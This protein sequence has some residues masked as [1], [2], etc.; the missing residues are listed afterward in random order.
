MPAG[1]Q[2][3]NAAGQLIFD[4]STRASRVLG[5]VNITG[6]VDGSVAN[7][8]FAQGDPYW[9]CVQTVGL[10]TLYFGVTPAFSF[11]GTTLSWSFDGL[12]DNDCLLIYGVY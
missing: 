3:W 8:D 6:G 12:P 5:L 9:Q 10:S 1:L 4:I 7:P 2:V 11:S